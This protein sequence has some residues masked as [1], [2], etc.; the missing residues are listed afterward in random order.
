MEK[1]KNLRPAFWLLALLSLPLVLMYG[2]LVLDTVS[3]TPPGALLPDHF[4]LKHWRFLWE[5]DAQGVSIWSVTLNSLIFAGSV[6]LIALSLSLTAGYAL[7]RLNI[8]FRRHLLAMVL[9]L[10]AFPSVT[11]LVAIFIVLQMIGLYNT[12]IGVILVF[13]ALQLPLGIWL[14]KGF[15]DGV[16]WEIEMA[17]LQDGASRFT[18][19]WRLVLPQIRPAIAAVGVFVFIT[20]WAEY[21]TP[22][23]LAPSSS[24]RVLSLYLAGLISNDQHFDFALFKSIGLFYIAPVLV[25]YAFTHKALMSIYGGGTKG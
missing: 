21:V 2:Y 1:R 12:L 20:G 13:A 15:Y 14:M 7:S 5:R 10:H 4:T 3:T 9:V 22:Q 25:F 24:T 23:V 11:L 19:W 18:V 6:T 16:P 8:P 17:G